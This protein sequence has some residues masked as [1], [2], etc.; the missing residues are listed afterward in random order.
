MKKIIFSMVFL[1]MLAAGLGVT[2]VANAEEQKNAEETLSDSSDASGIKVTTK[3]DKKN[4]KEGDTANI[5][6]SVTNTNE[7]DMTNVQVDYTLPA[8]Y[9]VTS[10]QVSQTVDSLAAGETKEFSLSAVVAADEKGDIVMSSYFTVPVLILI[11]VVALVLIG[12]VIFIIRKKI[13]PKKVTKTG[14]SIFVIL[15]LLGATLSYAAVPAVPVEAEE[16]SVTNDDYLPRVSVHDPSVVKDPKTGTYYVFGS[17]LAFAKST[18]LIHWER[19]TNNINTDYNELFAEPWAYAKAATPNGNLSGYM[20]APD[21]I[22]NDTMNK[23]CMYMS[24]DGDNWCSSICLL[25]AD[26]IEGPYEYKGIVVYSGMNNPKTPPDLSTTDVYKVLGEDADLTRYA[27][28]SNSCINA[29]DPSVKYD[30]NGDLYMSYGSW[31]AGIYMLKLDKTTGLRDYDTTYE[32]KLDVSDAY[33]GYK[34]AGGHYNSGEASYLMKAGD[35][36]YLFISY[37]GLSAIEGYQIRIYRSKSITGPYVD[38][39]GESPICTKSE[40]MKKTN[41]GVKIFGSYQMSGIAQVQVAQGHNSAFVD[42]DGKIYLVYH[43]RFQSN[44]G[45]VET[46]QIRVHQM[47]VNEDGWLVAA[48]Y[49][50]SGE[51]L[52]EEGYSADEVTGKYDFIYH[53]P[54]ESYNVINGEQYGIVGDE[55]E[56]V[57]TVELQKDLTVNHRVSSVK[58]S[59]SYGH[60]GSAKVEI[61]ADGTVTGDYSGTWKFTNGSNVEMVLNG[62]TYKGVFLKQQDESTDRKVRMTFTLLGDNVTVWGVTSDEGETN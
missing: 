42:D 58:I 11:V 31:S 20:W 62:V 30:E 9:S 43:T 28:T 53:E 44:T 47:F 55:E 19:F 14:A 8:K 16:G 57:Q 36:W 39:N 29:I 15:A 37:A 2:A 46:H 61:N 7:Y 38:Q 50:Y 33:L 54:T 1:L 4:Y 6:V 32:T 40:D 23:W 24:I 13:S 21:V 59:V 10:G 52:S 56:T 17:H 35:Y 45:K 25:T 60:E 27:N 26:D 34:I 12:L 3:A 22:W 5:T 48:P 41:L 51:T 18:D 49:E